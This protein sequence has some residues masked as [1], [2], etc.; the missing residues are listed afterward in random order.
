MAWIKAL[1]TN[2]Y[3]GR[4][5]IA[6]RDQPMTIISKKRTE[7]VHGTQSSGPPSLV[8]IAIL[9]NIFLDAITVVTSRFAS[10]SNRGI[11]VFDTVKDDTQYGS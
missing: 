3:D 11:D 2:L 7:R 9:P 6:N 8:V 5:V 4:S 10:V 1:H